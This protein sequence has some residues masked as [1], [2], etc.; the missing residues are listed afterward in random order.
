[1]IVVAVLLL[2]LSAWAH[3]T[4][5][6]TSTP[7]ATATSTATATNTFFVGTPCVRWAG[8]AWQGAH[9]C[10]VHPTITDTPTI[11]PTH[12]YQAPAGQPAIATRTPTP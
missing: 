6:R 11:T 2:P 9:L 1:M 7:T 3:P 4:R 10:E 5:T 12:Y 8:V